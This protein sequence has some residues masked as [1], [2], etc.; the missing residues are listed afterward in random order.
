LRSLPRHIQR[1]AFKNY[2]QWLR[3]QGHQSL[4][5]K[6]FKRDLWSARVGAHYRACGK[7]IGP[8]SFR[9]TWIGTHEE[10]NKL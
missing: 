6:K 9:W 4:H 8:G 10:Y 7:W 3:D 5:F 1:Q 2:Q